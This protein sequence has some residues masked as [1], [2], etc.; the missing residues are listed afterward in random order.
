MLAFVI[1]AIVAVIFFLELGVF[2]GRDPK[3][4]DR[5]VGTAVSLAEVVTFLFVIRTA[6]LAG[7]KPGLSFIVGMLG[8]ILGLV[9]FALGAN[10]GRKI[11]ED[12]ATREEQRRI[13]EFEL[14]DSD[15]APYHR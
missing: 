15:R 14:Y 9:I 2:D 13:A 11:T 4:K 10:L 1:F 5:Y 3:R 12:R 8:V 7:L 6:L